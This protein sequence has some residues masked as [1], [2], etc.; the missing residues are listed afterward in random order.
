METDHSRRGHQMDAD[1]VIVL[2]LTFG[3]PE[4]VAYYR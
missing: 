1:T 3:R 2:G 4:Q